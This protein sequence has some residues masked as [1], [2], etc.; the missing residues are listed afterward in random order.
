M[1]ARALLAAIAALAAVLSAVALA[2]VEAVAKAAQAPAANPPLVPDKG[3][4]RILLDGAEVGTEQFETDAAGNAWIVRG[5]TVARVQGVETR[6]SGQLR[7]SSDGA[8]LRYDWTAQA[9]KK[10]S[11]FVDFENGTAK[12]SIHLGGSDPYQQDFV[13]PSPRLA[14]LDNNLYHQY[15]LLAL[16][17]NWNAKGP[18]TFPVLI[19][20]DLT[21]GSV[22]VESLGG[23]T[24]EG[25]LLETLRVK[26]ADV[27][28]LAYFD[29]R[30]RLMR[31]E[32]PAAKVAI[33]RR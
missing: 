13:F 9:E 33:I 32:V 29:S 26:A 22:S 19:P 5:E 20:Q 8:P 16:L 17:Y 1:S 21:P 2:K 3:A 7:L 25:A 12:T 23:K 27:E 14:V 28:I 15:A 18:Q 6:S 24:V 10:I 11:G 30:R 4:F 31:L